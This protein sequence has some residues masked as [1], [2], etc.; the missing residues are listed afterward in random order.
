MTQEQQIKDALLWVKQWVNI[1]HP[2]GFPSTLT[3]IDG[4]LRGKMEAQEAA[5][6]VIN[7]TA[8]LAHPCLTN[9]RR[10]AR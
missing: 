6:E 8:H 2:R 4:A 7:A 3:F 9:L 1:L 5:S 10:F